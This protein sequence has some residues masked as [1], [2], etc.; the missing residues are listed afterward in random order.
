VIYKLVFISIALGSLLFAEFL[1][2]DIDGIE[3]SQDKCPDSKITDIVDEDGC[4]I[5]RL[6]YKKEH[7]FDISVGISYTKFDTNSSQTAQSL[8]L[9][10]YYGENLAINFYTSNYDLDSGD[11]GI[12]DSTLGINY[13]MEYDNSYYSMGAGLYLPTFDI[14]GNEVDY[15][16]K[17]KVALQK[18]DFSFSLYLQHT[19]INDTLTQ[20]TNTITLSS[21]VNINQSLYTS[22]SYTIQDSIYKNQDRLKTIELY[23]SYYFN[24]SFFINSSLSF[25]LNDYSIDKSYQI[26]LGYSY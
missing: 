3:N 22:L 20:D 13:M 6:I 2:D 5:E 18:E 4:S 9:S 24:N 10:Y 25:G 7:Y 19:F 12:D 17:A 21:G 16:L 8:Y 23:G 26:S 11:S 1:D 14:E 15:F